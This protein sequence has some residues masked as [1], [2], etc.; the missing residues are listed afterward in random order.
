MILREPKTIEIYGKSFV[1]NKVPFTAAREIFTQYVP[2]ALP[3]SEYKRNEELMKKLM[4]YVAVPH[5]TMGNLF[6]TTQELIDSHITSLQMGLKLEYA[7]IHYN[8]DF[9]ADG[10]LS[11][12][13]DGIAEKLPQ[14]ITKILTLLA[15]SLSQ[16]EKQPSES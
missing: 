8:V 4:S 6:L 13:F 3:R 5:E 2:S 12:F 9:L 1:L 7:M 16:K 10:S 14:W 11:T 15:P